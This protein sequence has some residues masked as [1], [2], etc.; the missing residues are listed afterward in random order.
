MCRTKVKGECRVESVVYKVWCGKCEGEGKRRIYVGE[1]GRSAWERGK[2]HLKAWR[3]K[4]EGSFMWKHQCNEHG[5]DGMEEG[6]IKMEVI[7]KPRKALQRQVEEAVRIGEEKPG[8]VMNSKKEFGH[9]KI[10]RIRIGMGDEVRGRREEWERERLKKEE[11][12]KREEEQR[13]EREDKIWEEGMEC[14]W[15]TQDERERWE[16]WR[17]EKRGAAIIEN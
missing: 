8:E 6:D 1:T 7:G 10:P 13:K 11:R 15:E 5:E 14:I 3:E 9:N 2:D 4:E 16:Q 12:A 17:G